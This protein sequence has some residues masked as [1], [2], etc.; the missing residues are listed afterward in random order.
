MREVKVTVNPDGTTRTDFAGYT[1]STCLD[2]AA[3]LRELLA[4]YGVQIEQTQFTPKPELT[5]AIE[6]STRTSEVQHE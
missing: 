1:G 4:A 5:Q 6:E 2:A 3:K